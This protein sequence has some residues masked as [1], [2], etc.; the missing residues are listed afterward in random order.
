MSNSQ[1]YK[2]RKVHQVMKYKGISEH[3]SMEY[4]LTIKEYYL[5]TEHN[6]ESENNYSKWNKRDQNI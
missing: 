1:N 6:I 5:Y 2:E 3:F 4:S